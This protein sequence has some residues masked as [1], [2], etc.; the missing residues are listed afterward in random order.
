MKTHSYCMAAA[1]ASLRRLLPVFLC[2]FALALAACK[3][4]GSSDGSK[5]AVNPNEVSLA[6]D[7]ALTLPTGWNV[8]GSIGPQAASK[9]SLDSRRQNNERVLLLE[10]LGPA[11]PRGLESMIAIF[12]VNEAGTFMPREYA[13]KLKPEEFD[14]LGKDLLAREKASAKKQKTKSGLLDVQVSRDSVGGKL[15]ISQRMLVAGQDGKPVRLINW[16]VYMPNGA[17]IAIKTVCDP[18]NPGAE[19]QISTMVKSLRIQ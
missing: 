8:A 18:E 10:A 7:T 15:T 11:G 2:C 9:Q 12:V 6:Y 13:E 16:D 19:N 5:S 14:A 4:T 1:P 17:G 3:T